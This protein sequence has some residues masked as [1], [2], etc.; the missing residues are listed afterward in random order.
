[1]YLLQSSVS[2]I[3]E[4]VDGFMDAFHTCCSRYYDVVAMKAEAQR[5]G[6]DG[7]NISV[8]IGTYERYHTLEAIVSSLRRQRLVG[9]I[10]VVVMDSGSTPPALAMLS[11][12]EADT[13]IYRRE[14]G[15]Y[16]RGRAFNEGVQASTHNIIAFLDD[17]VIPISEYWAFSFVSSFLQNPEVQVVRMPMA[18]DNSLQLSLDFSDAPSRRQEFENKDQNFFSYPSFTTCNMAM[19]KNAWEKVGGFDMSLDGKYGYEDIVF[20]HQA[21]EEGLQYTNGNI[22]GCAVHVGV[23]FRKRDMKRKRLFNTA[24]SWYNGRK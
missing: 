11:D 16:H 17:D 1:V 13:V 18:L 22:S 8:I 10:E 23:F 12:M 5:L 9:R 4:N 2:N 20:H 19:R 7:I 21:K 6:T 3:R 24:P 15:L 14:D